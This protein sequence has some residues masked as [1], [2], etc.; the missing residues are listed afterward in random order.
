MKELREKLEQRLVDIETM[1]NQQSKEYA[2]TQQKLKDLE[3]SM[4][5]LKGM[6]AEVERTIK[7]VDSLRRTEPKKC[8]DNVS[9]I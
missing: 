4:D 7:I 5:Q 1:F 2:K 6:Y 3:S 9:D 8:E